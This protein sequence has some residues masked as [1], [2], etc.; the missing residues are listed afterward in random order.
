MALYT[1]T[2]LPYAGTINMPLSVAPYNATDGVATSGFNT[3][4]IWPNSFIGPTGQTVTSGKPIGTPIALYHYTPTQRFNFIS[5]INPVSGGFLPPT[6]G[7]YWPGQ[8][9]FY[10]KSAGQLADNFSGGAYGN[11]VDIGIVNVSGTNNVFMTVKL[12]DLSITS[13]QANDY[14]WNQIYF[15]DSLGGISLGNVVSYRSGVTIAPYAETVVPLFPFSAGSLGLL[16]ERGVGATIFDPY[17]DTPGVNSAVIGASIPVYPYNI[18]RVD[19]TTY[20]KW[21]LIER[22]YQPSSFSITN[23]RMYTIGFDDPGLDSYNL[24]DDLR[25]ATMQP[26]AIGYIGKM[27]PTPTLHPYTQYGGR[28]HVLVPLS[29]DRYYLIQPVA[30]TG[31][32]QAN[33][34]AMTNNAQIMIDPVGTGYMTP[35]A[36][37]PMLTTFGA[38]FNINVPSIPPVSLTCTGGCVG[39]PYMLG[40]L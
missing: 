35:Y 19:Y 3:K 22:W 34:N 36:N 20:T 32:T 1:N 31:A 14:G 25:C 12:P 8:I 5:G 29:L 21:H 23:R 39:V 2:Q 4:S 40:I 24:I 16:V 18:C 6:F 7:N 38:F 27:I 13:F 30:W 17:E 11:Q 28:T 26:T 33:L 37:S 10:S 9:S 15:R